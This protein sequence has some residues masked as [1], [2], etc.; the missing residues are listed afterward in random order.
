MKQFKGVVIWQDRSKY[1]QEFYTYEDMVGWMADLPS[2]GVFLAFKSGERIA[3]I[4]LLI[5]VPAERAKRTVRPF[6]MKY[7]IPEGGER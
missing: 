6:E 7:T 2:G 1:S 5:D 3:R 4:K